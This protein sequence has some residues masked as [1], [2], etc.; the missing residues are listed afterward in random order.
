MIIIALDLF[1]NYR[2]GKKFSS[3]NFAGWM[4]LR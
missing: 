4:F 1:D 3:Y 2:L